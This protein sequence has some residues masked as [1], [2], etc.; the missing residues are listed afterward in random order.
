[1]VRQ[2]GGRRTDNNS[3][4]ADRGGARGGGTAGRGGSSG[5]V[6]RKTVF[7]PTVRAL[8]IGAAPLALSGS[9]E[10]ASA[11]ATRAGNSS[12]GGSGLLLV[13]RKLA[14]TTAT[15]TTSE[16]TA[17]ADDTP[18]AAAALGSQSN[19]TSQAK[20]G[21]KPV[22]DNPWAMRSQRQAA[23]T[24]AA[25]AA[26][27][28]TTTKASARP[29]AA[30]LNGRRYPQTMN[31]LSSMPEAACGDGDDESKE[32]WDEMLDNGF[33]FSQ[34]IEFGDGTAVRIN[35]RARSKLPLSSMPSTPTAKVAMAEPQTPHSAAE[36]GPAQ[37]S[38]GAIQD[39]LPPT[40]GTGSTVEPPT[41]TT[42]ELPATIAAPAA[43]VEL[44]PTTPRAM[45][46]SWGKPA[47]STAGASAEDAAAPASSRW[48]K[49]SL[50]S[51]STSRPLQQPM[52]AQAVGSRSSTNP[53]T[54]PAPGRGNVPTR[55]EASDGNSSSNSGSAQRGGRGERGPRPGR[56]NRHNMAPIPTVVPPVLLRRPTQ[57]PT[58]ALDEP[59]LV[60]EQ[61]S[62][63]I[64]EPPTLPPTV[65]EPK[66]KSNSNDNAN[67]TPPAKA[68]TVA[69]KQQQQ[70]L[71]VAR[72]EASASVPRNPKK[73]AESSSRKPNGTSNSISEPSRLAENWRAGTAP[74]PPASQPTTL[75]RVTTPVTAGDGSVEAARVPANAARRRSTGAAKVSGSGPS[76]PGPRPLA[77]Q[78]KADRTTNSIKHSAAATATNW[79][80]GTKPAAEASSN[81][82][83]SEET[84]GAI[85]A[86]RQR[87]QTQGAAGSSRTT[88]HGAYSG[89]SQ[90][91]MNGLVHVAPP[92][93][94]V[95][96]PPLLPQT[97]LADILDEHEGSAHGKQ[98]VCSPVKPPAP[99]RGSSSSGATV[100]AARAAEKSEAPAISRQQQSRLGYGGAPV[101]SNLSSS[102]FNV[103]G[104]PLM[105]S[106]SSYTV[107]VRPAFGHIDPGLF[108]WQGSHMGF[109][110]ARARQ[111][112]PLPAHSASESNSA[113]RERPVR[114]SNTSGTIGELP[115]QQQQQQQPH[116]GVGSAVTFSSFSAGAGMLWMDPTHM[117][118]DAEGRSFPAPMDSRAS[119]HGDGANT[120]G[121]VSG[122]STG[123]PNGFRAP[124]RALRPIGTR[125]VPGNNTQRNTRSRQG[126]ANQQQQQQ[127]QSY[128]HGAPSPVP[129][130]SQHPLFVPASHM[131]QSWLPHYSLMQPQ[132]PPLTYGS[133]VAAA[134]SGARFGR[135]SPRY[136]PQ[137]TETPSQTTSGSAAGPPGVAPFMT[138]LTHSMDHHQSMVV[139]MPAQP[140]SKTGVASGPF[141]NMPP[142]QYI[143]ESFRPS[144][145]PPPMYQYGYM[146]GPPP[147]PS[148]KQGKAGQ[149]PVTTMAP[150]PHYHHGYPPQ[151]GMPLPNHTGAPPHMAFMPMYIPGDHSAIGSNGNPAYYYGQQQPQ[152]GNA[153]LQGQPPYQQQPTPQLAGY[154]S[155]MQMVDAQKQGYLGYQG[156]QQQMAATKQA[157]KL[158]GISRSSSTSTRERGGHGSSKG[159]GIL[160]EPQQANLS[161]PPAA[162]A[163]SADAAVIPR[164]GSTS[165][166]HG[167]AA[168]GSAPQAKAGGDRNRQRGS[169][170]RN[171]RKPAP[172]TNDPGEASAQPRDRQQQKQRTD[173]KRAQHSGPKTDDKARKQPPRTGN[174]N[175]PHEDGKAEQQGSSEKP[176]RRNRGNN[177]SGRGGGKKSTQ[178]SAKS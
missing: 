14:A 17:A 67:P 138:P 85:G 57:P 80:A 26:A 134:T 158:L 117:A 174:S 167:G 148:T 132:P 131:H 90:S 27:A 63:I 129:Q 74:K 75:A 78:D 6:A 97:M 142:A 64:V 1:M 120:S 169:G 34:D 37:L 139:S 82:P 70:A 5:G 124:G 46:S 161:L 44:P 98:S 141:A 50:S 18:N 119:S 15:A 95:S 121:S 113:S 31:S 126:G 69:Q 68:A 111:E 123:G 127:S 136:S 108:T 19:A 147:P 118:Y 41:N 135:A 21:P 87:A 66:L 20:G 10:L 4:T 122:S 30:M 16:T 144:P 151:L 13:N 100:P 77:Q 42:P 114:W 93:T 149:S 81:T 162:A 83:V 170:G 146:S 164:T 107:P 58:I 38:N 99:S 106:N 9:G 153:P 29:T 103:E 47:K 133:A 145:P 101:V 62:T 23:A 55:V 173:A 35:S 39:S 116:G 89:S 91:Q 152:F 159:P 125:N 165:K 168:S 73:A 140:S 176:A 33:D 24:A 2:G 54:T 112:Y 84:L 49:A 130:S 178:T 60:P 157:E 76:A 86:G 40:K 65:G 94:L 96:S 109:H 56:G 51:N 143:P 3:A 7:R 110:D 71:P 79:R 156:E 88:V 102:L 155:A 11:D 22:S 163:G 137:M 160:P 150:A 166:S 115:P 105:G 61:A 154:P 59:C 25:A 53:N 36:A 72:A 32:N 45:E 104:S 43:A 12:K 177:R 92:A 48:W 172:K 128:V 175:G 8:P 52:Q 28:T 171:E